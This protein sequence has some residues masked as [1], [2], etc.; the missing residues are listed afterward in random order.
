MALSDLEK[1]ELQRAY[2]DASKKVAE[3]PQRLKD[4]FQQ[5]EAE[6]REPV[7]LQ[8]L[9]SIRAVLLVKAMEGIE[10]DVPKDVA[11][12]LGGQR[13]ACK[14]LAADKKCEVILHSD[15][16]LLL[17]DAAGLGVASA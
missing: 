13:R 8:P 14:R 6:E 10:G 12:I 15:Q 4:E 11:E 7:Q 9:T 16:L 3:L 2:K 5:A 17:L 1:L